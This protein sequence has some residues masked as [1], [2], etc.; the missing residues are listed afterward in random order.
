MQG[1]P[2]N[3]GEE[4]KYF[5]WK[6][7]ICDHIVHIIIILILLFMTIWITVKTVKYILAEQI[8]K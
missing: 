1:M 6:D 3:T 5:S 7:R 4:K 2:K 8:W